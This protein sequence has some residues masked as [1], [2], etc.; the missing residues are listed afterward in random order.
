MMVI[1][2]NFEKP[3]DPE[4]ISKVYLPLD[5]E[6]PDRNCSIIQL[7]FIDS[8]W[9]ILQDFGEISSKAGNDPVGVYSWGFLVGRMCDVEVVEASPDKRRSSLELSHE[10]QAELAV[11]AFKVGATW[12]GKGSYRVLLRKILSGEVKCSRVA[13]NNLFGRVR[14][15]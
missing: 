8:A 4:V 14:G 1:Q 5:G 9:R 11:I 10:E 2:G 15:L 3:E 12:R 13:T 7:R 6:A